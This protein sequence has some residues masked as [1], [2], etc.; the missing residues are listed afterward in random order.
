MN[1]FDFVVMLI[2]FIFHDCIPKN[3]HEIKEKVKEIALKEDENIS[4][5][6]IDE[7]VD[8]IYSIVDCADYFNK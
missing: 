7:I 2:A 6:T 4:E 8:R 5:H 3:K 1:S